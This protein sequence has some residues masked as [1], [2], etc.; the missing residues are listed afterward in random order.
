MIFN[1]QRR[2]E[3][4]T[5]L[6]NL[7]FISALTMFPA[8]LNAGTLSIDRSGLADNQKAL[9]LDPAGQVTIGR[10]LTVNSPI[11]ITG[12]FSVNGIVNPHPVYGLIA[13][14]SGPLANI[15]AGW[16]LCNGNNGTPDLRNLFIVGADNTPSSDYYFNKTGGSDAVA[17]SNT[18]YLPAHS[19]IINNIASAGDHF[20]PTVGATNPTAVRGDVYNTTKY[21]MNSS[22]Q[23][24]TGEAGDHTHSIQTSI[25]GGGAAHENR[26]PYYALAYI[27]KL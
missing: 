13:I 3:I 11:N 17:L 25:D 22:V 12:S 2:I 10:N 16:T 8:L 26:P 19:H 20:H 21:K 15:P 14:W 4:A 23:Y 6:Q 1:K 18:S 7:G 24:Q 5:L 9:T 27:M